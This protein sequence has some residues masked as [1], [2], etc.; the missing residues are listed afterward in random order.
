MG[1]VTIG[2]QFA[3]P[4]YVQ[5]STELVTC[6]Q[7]WRWTS[8]EDENA[9]LPR[10]DVLCRYRVTSKSQLFV[11]AATEVENNLSKRLKMLI[12]KSKE[13][14]SGLAPERFLIQFAF[15]S[16]RFP[17]TLPLFQSTPL[18]INWW[19]CVAPSVQKRVHTFLNCWWGLGLV[20]VCSTGLR[21]SSF[22]CVFCVQRIGCRS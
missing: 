14:I 22:H 7:G 5:L 11:G 13:N 2:C 9:P 19:R 1:P 15:V 10:D 16:N 12:C 18:D 3:G 20:L 6:P 17:L 21:L 8:R 4:A